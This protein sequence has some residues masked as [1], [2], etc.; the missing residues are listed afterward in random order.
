MKD[1]ETKLKEKQDYGTGATRDAAK[2]KGRFDL[3]PDLALARLAGVYERGALNHGARNWEQ[4]LPISRLI[5]SATRHLVQYKMSKYMPELDDEDHLAHSAWNILAIIHME[6]MI[7]RGSLQK[8]LDDLPRYERLQQKK[9]CVELNSQDIIKIENEL[10]PLSVDI[11]TD[12]RT[13]KIHHPASGHSVTKFRSPDQ[14]HNYSCALKELK[15]ILDHT[16]ETRREE[17]KKKIEEYF[18][19]NAPVKPTDFDFGFGDEEEEKF[20]P[21]EK[22]ARSVS[23]DRVAKR[24]SKHVCKG[25]RGCGRHAEKLSKK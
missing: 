24:G 9:E 6:E 15:D 18:E 7:K 21:H 19:E 8:E 12:Q 20:V 14:R 5:D 1:Y 3:I 25:G 17:K 23:L 13:V 4:G 2:G 22:A 10:G 11:H 16:E